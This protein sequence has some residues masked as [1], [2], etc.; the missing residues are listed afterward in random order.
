MIKLPVKILDI[1]S[2]DTVM[3]ISKETASRLK[4]RHDSLITLKSNTQD[5]VSSPIVVQGIIPDDIVAISPS[6]AKWLGVEENDKVTILA[7]KPPQS[8][9]FIKRKIDPNR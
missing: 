9:D 1:R 8:Y 5:M 7:R 2:V 6:D 4:L 3:M